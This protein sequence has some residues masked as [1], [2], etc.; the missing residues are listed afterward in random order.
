[1]GHYEISENLC[2][3]TF[4]YMLPRVYIY[5]YLLIGRVVCCFLGMFARQISRTK[6]LYTLPATNDQQ[7]KFK[8]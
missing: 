4:T 1:M 8:H 3:Y 2:K 5:I 6:S 7:I